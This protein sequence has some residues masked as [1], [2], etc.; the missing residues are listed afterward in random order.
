M[1]SNSIYPFT[2]HLTK[3]WVL[4]KLVL[5]S[6]TPS[7]PATLLSDLLPACEYS[8]PAPCENHKHQSYSQSDIPNVDDLNPAIL[9]KVCVKKCREDLFTLR[10][11]IL[12]T[13][14]KESDLITY[15]GTAHPATFIIDH[16]IDKFD[17]SCLVKTSV[18]DP[19][20]TKLAVDQR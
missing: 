3:H 10:T 8:T 17:V 6:S 20:V 2:Q 13:C 7:F 9:E 18:P 1:A 12:E 16:Y 14:D 19:L 11:E 4:A 15:D 5:K